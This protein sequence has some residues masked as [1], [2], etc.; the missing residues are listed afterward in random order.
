M[1]EPLSLFF[2]TEHNPEDTVSQFREKEIVPQKVEGS[3]DVIFQFVTKCSEAY[4][5]SLC[6]FP[7]G[8]R[9]HQFT[10]YTIK[11]N[12]DSNKR[13][14][15]EQAV[16][17]LLPCS[18]FKWEIADV[19]SNITLFEEFLFTEAPE[20]DFKLFMENARI[21]SVDGLVTLSWTL[22]QPCIVEYNIHLCESNS[23]NCW[24]GVFDRPEVHEEEDLFISI[25]L[26]SLKD[27]QFTF[28]ECKTYELTILTLINQ[29]PYEYLLTFIYTDEVH[30][31]EY[32]SIEET[33]SDSLTV[34]WKY[35]NC[36]N[37][38]EVV[39]EVNDDNGTISENQAAAGIDIHVVKGLQSC[40]KYDIQVYTLESGKK[41]K[42]SVKVAAVTH[43]TEEV[44]D[45]QVESQTSSI[46]VKMSN[47]SFNCIQHWTSTLC[48]MPKN[49]CIGIVTDDC[50][51]KVS[52]QTEIVF[53]DLEHSA[54]FIVSSKATLLDE[55]SFELKDVCIKTKVCI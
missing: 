22:T 47:I 29:Q 43:P 50:V 5:L 4:F 52:N 41:S 53:E 30:K 1:T 35:S 51:S 33:T 31:P 49:S 39:I 21:E 32:V 27:F 38:R 3:D 23:S 28:E 24:S 9:S 46:Y 45:L 15:Y 54:Y 48:K 16:S 11:N 37:S 12:E 34:G 36:S 42:D 20:D 13:G 2:R 10:T 44:F 14:Y 7:H 25:E 26:T 19:P 6:H 17:H 8:C 55:T 18:V 40:T